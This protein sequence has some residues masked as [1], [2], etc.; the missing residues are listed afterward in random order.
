[1]IAKHQNIGTRNRFAFR[2]S[3]Q[4]ALREHGPFIDNRGFTISPNASMT[5]PFTLQVSDGAMAFDDAVVIE[6]RLLKMAIDVTCKNEVIA[7]L[8]PLS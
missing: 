5:W 2:T 1:M 6:S 8:A 3:R 4:L 7:L